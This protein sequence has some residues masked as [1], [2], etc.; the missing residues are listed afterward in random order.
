M[1]MTTCGELRDFLATQ[2]ADRLIILPKDDDGRSPLAAAAECM[3]LP[4]STWYGATFLTP[5]ERAAMPVPEAYD[6]APEDAIRVVVLD[7]TD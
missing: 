2:P 6:E 5:E 4:E 7:L 3:Y 1:N